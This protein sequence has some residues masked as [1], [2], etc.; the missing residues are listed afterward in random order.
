MSGVI[1]KGH[2]PAQ[3]T[4]D[5]GGHFFDLLVAATEAASPGG[6]RASL[7]APGAEEAQMPR[8]SG[9]LFCQKQHSDPLR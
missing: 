3:G 8:L 9:H 5:F 6:T 4:P 2:L 7:P 1:V